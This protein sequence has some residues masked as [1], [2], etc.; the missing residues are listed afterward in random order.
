MLLHIKPMKLAI[1]VL[2][3]IIHI[4]YLFLIFLLDCYNL[5]DCHGTLYV[6]FVPENNA[7]CYKCYH[8]SGSF[9]QEVVQ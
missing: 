5:S 6:S 2:L 9:S 7:D 3:Y 8:R 4:V 1:S